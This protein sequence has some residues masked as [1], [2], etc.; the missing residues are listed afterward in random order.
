[1]LDVALILIGAHSLRVD[2]SIYYMDS[3]VLKICSTI[4]FHFTASMWCF[5]VCLHYFLLVDPT[6]CRKSARHVRAWDA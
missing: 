1:M 2:F 6:E 4:T 5:L 3:F